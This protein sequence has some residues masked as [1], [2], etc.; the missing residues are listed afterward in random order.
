MFYINTE[1]TIN[2]YQLMQKNTDQQIVHG[3]MC[4]EYD[5]TK[6]RHKVWRLEEEL[7]KDGVCHWFTSTY[8]ANTL[9]GSR[10]KSMELQNR[11]SN[12]HCEICRWHCATA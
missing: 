6:W 5:W 2:C 12:L 10:L 7:D 9:A 4:E 1:S 8:T 3:S 11:T